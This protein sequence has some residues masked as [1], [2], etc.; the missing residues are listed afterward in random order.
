LFRTEHSKLL[1]LEIQ[2]SRTFKTR[3]RLS[4]NNLDIFSYVNSK[5]VY[6]EKHIK[7]QL[8]RLYQDIMK[9]KCA[10]ER[11][12]PQNALPDTLAT[13]KIYTTKDLDSMLNLLDEKSLNHIAESAARR[14]WQ[15]FVT[16]G[17]ASAGGLAIFI[18]AKL[19]KLIIVESKNAIINRYH[20]LIYMEETNI[21]LIRELI[22][23]SRKV[24][25]VQANVN[26]A[27]TYAI[28]MHNEYIYMRDSY[29]IFHAN[30]QDANPAIAKTSDLRYPDDRVLKQYDKMSR[31]KKWTGPH[32][33]I[34]KH[35]DVNYTIKIGQKLIRVHAN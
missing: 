14:V 2:R 31:E 9:Q 5:F 13:S 20:P 33:V 1:I 8:T 7:N 32:T 29:L 30:E 34:E 24:N 19:E 15:E 35:N 12:I 23:K 22:D 26:F 11:Q 21:E 27:E 25:I 16:F 6:V 28:E 17:S 18:M 10:L 3:S 4:V